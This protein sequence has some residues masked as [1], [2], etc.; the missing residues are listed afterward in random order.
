[1]S[2]FFKALDIQEDI[3]KQM[4][5]IQTYLEE[6]R[7]IK[8]FLNYKIEVNKL[9]EL[10]FLYNKVKGDNIIAFERIISSDISFYEDLLSSQG[11]IDP[12]YLTP[13]LIIMASKGVML[14]HFP[15]LKSARLL[16]MRWILL[17]LLT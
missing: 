9:D 15:Q 8:F 14:Y 2:K 13:F 5:K 4:C 10:H 16:W 7:N 17:K 6:E 1:M 12:N 3:W 11:D